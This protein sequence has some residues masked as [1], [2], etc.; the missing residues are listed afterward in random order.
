M[1]QYPSSPDPRP[2]SPH[3]SIYRPQIT[4][5][6]SITHRLTGVT[7]FVGI[8]FLCW[9][10]FLSAYGCTH[11]LNVLLRSGVFQGILALWSGALYYHMLNG[12]RHL[13]WD[14]GRGFSLS[15]THRSGWAVV[16]LAIVATALTWAAVLTDIHF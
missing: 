2:L 15:A 7:L 12:I 14:S 3:L 16:M 1:T 13:F 9:W 8:I 4:T 10:V 6:L 11:C 5:M